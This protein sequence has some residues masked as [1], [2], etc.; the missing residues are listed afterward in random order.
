MLQKTGFFKPDLE[1][2][3]IPEMAPTVRFLKVFIFAF[4]LEEALITLSKMTQNFKI[5]AYLMH[6]FMERDMKNFLIP[7]L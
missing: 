6:S 1:G 3:Y 4:F 7:E 5:R 2:T